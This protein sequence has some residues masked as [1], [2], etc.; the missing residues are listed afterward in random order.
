MWQKNYSVV[1]DVPSSRLWQVIA[2]VANWSAWDDDIEF[3]QMTGLLESGS[4]FVLKPKGAPAVKLAIEELLPPHR[5]TDVTQFPLAT[6]RTIH[7]FVDTAAG[8]EIQVTVQVQG[9]LGFLWQRIVAQKQ[10]DGLPEQTQRFI[11]RARQ[12][13]T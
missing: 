11:Q 4:G 5:F 3:T 2:D 8:T 1:T 12:I 7:E 9:I 13:T 6:M 10:V